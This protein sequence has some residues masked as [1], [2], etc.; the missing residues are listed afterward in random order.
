MQYPAVKA[1]GLPGLDQA[2]LGEKAA[3][4]KW[5]NLRKPPARTGKVEI[6]QGGS[7]AE[8]AAMLVDKLIAEKVI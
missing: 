4:L 2:R 3:L 5:T 6:I 8:T 1:A 7:P